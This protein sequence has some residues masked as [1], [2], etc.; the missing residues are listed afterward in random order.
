MRGQEWWCLMPLSTIVQFYHGGQFYWWRKSEYPEKT[1]DKL[2]PKMLHHVYLAWAG[3]ELTTLVVDISWRQSY[4]SLESVHPVDSIGR[5]E[6]LTALEA[7]AES[8][9]L[10]EYTQL[11]S[12]LLFFSHWSNKYMW[13]MDTMKCF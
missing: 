2:Y 8:N 12:F 7:W 6:D 11:L 4:T 9:A 3:F 13:D 1:T 5:W 10:L